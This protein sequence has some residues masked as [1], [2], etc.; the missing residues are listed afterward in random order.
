LGQPHWD[1]LTAFTGPNLI[2]S[3]SIDSA[4]AIVFRKPDLRGGNFFSSLLIYR[5]VSGATSA[6]I[7]KIHL[8]GGRNGY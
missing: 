7:T 4:A 2:Q 6:I 5:N 3:A 8:Q 1:L